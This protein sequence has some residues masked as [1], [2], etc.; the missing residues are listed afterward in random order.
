M[1]SPRFAFV[2][3]GPPGA[4][5]SS[6][7]RELA[8]LTGAAVLDLDSLTNPLVDVV[9]QA[10]GGEGY[11]DDRVGPLVREARYECLLRTAEDC[12]R[13]G[14]PVVLVAPFTAERTDLT[15]WMGM[16]TRLSEAGGDA[17]LVWLRI[18][19]E[20]LGRRLRERGAERDETKL[21]DLTSYLASLDLSP[22]DTPHLA[23]DAAESPARQAHELL[24]R[25]KSL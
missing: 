11:D 21:R 25:V 24:R 8:S 19:R 7:G 17:C 13:A 10:L 6:T 2:M 15:A 5:K 18:S 12:L 20:E 16:A 22:P 14:T 3:T 9:V 23:V 4:G 1:I